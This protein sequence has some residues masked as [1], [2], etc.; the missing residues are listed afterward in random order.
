MILNLFMFWVWGLLINSLIRN[1]SKIQISFKCIYFGIS[2]SLGGSFMSYFQRNSFSE[3]ISE[4][5]FIT[6]VNN[7]SYRICNHLTSVTQLYPKIFHTEFKL[8]PKANVLQL[9][10]LFLSLHLLAHCLPS[11]TKF[12]ESFI[13][14]SAMIWQARRTWLPWWCY[15]FPGDMFLYFNCLKVQSF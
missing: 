14:G 11:S 9:P 10:M 3:L 4:L 5:C 12:P 15:P 7:N 6:S 1:F 8:D 13:N 2:F